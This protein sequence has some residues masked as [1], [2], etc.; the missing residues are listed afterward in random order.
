M[1]FNMA[2]YNER[3]LV[4]LDNRVF[5]QA[6][7]QLVGRTLFPSLNVPRTAPAYGYDVIKTTGKARRVGQS[8]RNTDT[9]VGDSTKKRFYVPM[10]EW[11]YGIEYTDR[12]VEEAQAA[13]DT[14]FLNRKANQA[15]RAMA[16]YED[17]VIF[18]GSPEDGINGI[19]SSI[20]DTGFQ[21]LVPTNKGGLG[22]MKPEEIRAYFKSASHLITDL[23]YSNAKPVLLIT[24][25]IE[26][27]LDNY[28]NEYRDKT[29]EDEISKYF[30][31]I[32]VAKELEPK[33]TD[34]DLDMGLIYL[35]D[36][37][38][39]VIP[40]AIKLERDWEEHFEGRTKIHYHE[41]FGGVAVRH[42]SH[43]VQLPDL[44]VPD[45]KKA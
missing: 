32:V 27:A 6:K 35:K 18:N 14:D 10:T 17:K 37:E 2:T 11:E 3:S 28:F 33:F 12:Q 15:A 26:S 1:A 42:P 21:E 22:A 36:E 9:P 24:D 40:T 13:K 16:E 8:G 34:R 25:A 30:D 7:M 43:F 23:H 39:A 29:I 20:E 19:T 44:I 38:T 5:E 41:K 45:K 4:A 31:S